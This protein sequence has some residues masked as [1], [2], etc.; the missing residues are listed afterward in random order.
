MVGGEYDDG[1]EGAAARSGPGPSPARSL[2]RLN[3]ANEST[4]MPTE[5]VPPSR[6]LETPS[7]SPPPVLFG[8]CVVFTGSADLVDLRLIKL[9]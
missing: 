6:A 1:V 8:C 4:L 9:T 2:T 5:G 7:A 3:D